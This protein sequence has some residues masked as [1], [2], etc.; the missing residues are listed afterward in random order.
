MCLVLTASYL[1]YSVFQAIADY[2]REKQREK[3]DASKKRNSV[4]TTPTNATPTLTPRNPRPS[5][6][7][8][9]EAVTPSTTQPPKRERSTVQTHL[10]TELLD[11]L[12]QRGSGDEAL[13]GVCGEGH[14]EEPNVIV[15]CERCDLAVHQECYGV[16]E[17]PAGEWLCAPCAVA[18][19]KL[20]KEGVGNDAIVA[21]RRTGEDGSRAVD[22]A[23]CPVK[24]GAFK[25]TTDKRKWVHVVGE[26][27]SNKNIV[28]FLFMMLSYLPGN[29]V[30][31]FENL[32]THRATRCIMNPSLVWYSKVLKS[33]LYFS[34]LLIC[35]LFC[36][37]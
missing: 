9:P 1:A 19:D 18:E 31:V 14:S 30:F 24:W 2:R 3:R 29:I 11:P 10:S 17:V 35:R 22:C 32:L 25:M 27:V 36:R 4:A 33:A 5:R 37:Q 7:F 13:C 23:L 26:S 20:R 15:F 28:Y 16:G 8:Y 21:G 6:P 12:A 34:S